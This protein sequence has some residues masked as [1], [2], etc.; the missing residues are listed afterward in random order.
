MT[1]RPHLLLSRGEL[2]EVHRGLIDG[3]LPGHGAGPHLEGDVRGRGWRR[4]A[5]G[6][7]TRRCW[8]LSQQM[9]NKVNTSICP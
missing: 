5:H 3:K 1:A 8:R 9:T 6:A 7:R 2:P 4:F